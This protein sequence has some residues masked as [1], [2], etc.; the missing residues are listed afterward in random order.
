MIELEEDPEKILVR[1]LT[2]LKEEYDRIGEEMW[3]VNKELVLLRSKRDLL[4]K[5]GE[6]LMKGPDHERDN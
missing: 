5:Q 1:Q 3:R 6:W 2:K 4:K